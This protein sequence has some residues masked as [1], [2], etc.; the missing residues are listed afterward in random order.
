MS[1]HGLRFVM[2]G[3]WCVFLF[4]KVRCFWMSKFGCVFLKSAVSFAFI[5]LSFLSSYILKRGRFQVFLWS[6]QIQVKHRYGRVKTNRYIT[7]NIFFCQLLFVIAVIA[8]YYSGCY[9]NS[10]LDVAEKPKILKRF[11]TI[12]CTKVACYLK[13]SSCKVVLCEQSIIRN[14]FSAS[15]NL[16]QCWLC[17]FSKI[18][19]VVY[20]QCCVLIG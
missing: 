11:L 13:K 6:F 5:A 16:V 17:H 19:L 7:T 9:G 4:F 2:G 15:Q 3:F 8:R 12:I 20:Y 10:S 18:Q 14:K 1:G